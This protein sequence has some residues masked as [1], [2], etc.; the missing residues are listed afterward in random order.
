M[1]CPTRTGLQ[2]DLLSLNRRVQD[3]SSLSVQQLCVATLAQHNMSV[4]AQAGP[5]P[6]TLA[7]A[8][9]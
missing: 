8:T 5:G 4:E 9:H 2:L 1:D 6:A 3:S 7:T